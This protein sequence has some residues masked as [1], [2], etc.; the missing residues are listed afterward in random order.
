MD[1]SLKHSAM[2]EIV[3]YMQYILLFSPPFVLFSFILITTSPNLIPYKARA[4]INPPTIAIPPDTTFPAALE[5][6]VAGAEV[7]EL[8]DPEEV[9]VFGTT[10]VEVETLLEELESA[11][12]LEVVVVTEE[13]LLLE[14]E[15]EEV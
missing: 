5:D 8:G 13:L 15:V 10:T 14:E 3:P 11:L 7:V 2:L 6:C 12:E 9:V 4:T 1:I